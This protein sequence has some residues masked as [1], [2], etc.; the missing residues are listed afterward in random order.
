MADLIRLCVEEF[1]DDTCYWCNGDGYDVP[2]ENH[3]EHGYWDPCRR[4]GGSGVDRDI[5]LLTR[6]DDPLADDDRLGY[7]EALAR[8]EGL[9]AGHRPTEC[10][11]A[12][13]I[14]G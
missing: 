4:C 2:F 6:G 9:V 11:E 13:P 12:S 8:G 1:G 5:P 14:D 3:W 7:S 10:E